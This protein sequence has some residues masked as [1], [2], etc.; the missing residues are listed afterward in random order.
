MLVAWTRQGTLQDPYE[1][2]CVKEARF[3]DKRGLDADYIDEYWERRYTLRDGASSG[4]G[5]AGGGKKAD[6]DEYAMEGD[7]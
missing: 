2:F 1:E 6:E 7:K 5:D 3:I 4:S